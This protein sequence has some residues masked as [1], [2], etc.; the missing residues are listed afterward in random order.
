[1]PAAG[2]AAVERATGN[3]GRA[4]RMPPGRKAAA[5]LARE[6]TVTAL[7]QRRHMTVR[8][9]PTRT[10][11]ED[12]GRPTCTKYVLTLMVHAVSNHPYVHTVTCLLGSVAGTDEDRVTSARRA[13]AAAMARQPKAPRRGGAERQMDGTHANAAPTDTDGPSSPHPAKG[14]GDAA[15]ADGGGGDGKHGFT[16]ANGRVPAAPAVPNGSMAGGSGRAEQHANGTSGV[17]PVKQDAAPSGSRSQVAGQLHEHVRQQL[18]AAPFPDQRRGTAQDPPADK[19]SGQR[20][21]SHMRFSGAASGGA[22]RQGDLPPM[23]DMHENGHAKPR[24]LVVD[25]PRAAGHARAGGG[26]QQRRQQPP[27][28][29]FGTFTDD[30]P[31]KSG[32]AASPQPVTHAGHAFNQSVAAALGLAA[33]QSSAAASPAMSPAAAAGGKSQPGQPA[34]A[35]PAAAPAGSAATGASVSTDGSKG[36]VMTERSQGQSNDRFQQDARRG[37]GGLASRGGRGSHRGRHSPAHSKPERDVR[38]LEVVR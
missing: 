22:V 9:L 17:L 21:V 35:T 13:A 23:A 30:G 10:L 29:Q 1:M 18:Q 24:V 31:V 37:R 4:G 32:P 5:V 25:P 33:V 34:A 20:A 2:E 26:N 3:S 36:A 7:R 19:L 15:A 11:E 27:I 14:N 38:V 6:A 8:C 16:T 28:M 12:V